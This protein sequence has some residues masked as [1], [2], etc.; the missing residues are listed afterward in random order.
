MDITVTK[1]GDDAYTVTIGDTDL[2]L[3]E[4]DLKRLLREGAKHLAPAP[5]E[6]PSLEEKTARFVRRIKAADDIRI[7]K[8]LGIADHG[9]VLVLLKT[10]EG[11]KE[12]LGKLHGNM[13][14]R[15]RKMCEE[16]LDFKFKDSVPDADVETSIQRL[17]E[18]ANELEKQGS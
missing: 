13:S 2:V 3:D 5:K 16:D 4:N 6:E 14:E 9:D 15:S 11:D 7:Q 8:L 18:A 17:S 10:A 12:L 1:T